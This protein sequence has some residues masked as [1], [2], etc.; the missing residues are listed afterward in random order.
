MTKN[1]TKGGGER[2]AL[3]SKTKKRNCNKKRRQNNR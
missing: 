1:M 2:K 3:G